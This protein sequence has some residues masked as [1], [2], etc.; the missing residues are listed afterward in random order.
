MGT[1]MIYYIADSYVICIS[2]A[3]NDINYRVKRRIRSVIDNGK[4]VQFEFQHAEQL[5]P[6][7]VDQSNSMVFE[8][9]QYGFHLK[10]HYS[11]LPNTFVRNYLVRPLRV[12]HML[13]SAVF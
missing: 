11:V 13:E 7:W 1:K 4:F 6:T 12:L 10:I 5:T 3:G 2:L 8:T 9:A